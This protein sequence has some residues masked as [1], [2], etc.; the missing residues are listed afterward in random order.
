MCGSCVDSSLACAIWI[1]DASTVS[2][3][4]RFFMYHGQ[5][6]GDA[7]SLFAAA[8]AACKKGMELFH[9][10]ANQKYFLRQIKAMDKALT[11][12]AIV[13]AASLTAKGEDGGVYIPKEYDFAL[14]MVYGHM[15]AAG[16]SY[17]PALSSIHL[18]NGLY[19]MLIFN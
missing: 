15:L 11:G 2:E 5:F 4:S 3:V 18:I 13:G 1:E 9:D 10:S 14:L 19:K 6:Q 8:L 17:I 16:R 7:Y 12:K